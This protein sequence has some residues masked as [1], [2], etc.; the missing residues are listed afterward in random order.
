MGDFAKDLHIAVEDIKGRI[1]EVMVKSVLEVRS[2]LMIRSPVDTGR[3]RA[4]WQL[5]VDSAPEGSIEVTIPPPPPGFPARPSTHT[6]FIVNNLP[7][8]RRLET[9]WSPQTPP[10]GMVGLTALEWPQIVAQAVA[11]VQ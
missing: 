11:S 7:Y 8:A 6:F 5:G 9:G 3:F 1:D 10:G 2:R 4:N